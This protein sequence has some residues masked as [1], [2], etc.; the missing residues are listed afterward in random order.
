MTENRSTFS[1]LPPFGTTSQNSNTAGITAR[2]TDKREKTRKKNRTTHS[3]GGG[4]GGKKVEN[5]EEG[6]GEVKEVDEEQ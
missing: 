2:P 4:G 1:V 5:E 6:E 3:S